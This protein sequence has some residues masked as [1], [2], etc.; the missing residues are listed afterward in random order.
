MKYDFSENVRCKQNIS[1][2][3]D[4]NLYCVEYINKQYKYMSIELYKYM[5]G[6]ASGLQTNLAKCSVTPIFGGDDILPKIVDILGCQ[7]QEF[8]IRYLGL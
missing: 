3:Y 5:F 6:E 2:I 7:V 8:P 1:M 4:Y